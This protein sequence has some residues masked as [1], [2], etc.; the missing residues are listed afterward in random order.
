MN[1]LQ[2]FAEETLRRARLLDAAE[3]KHVHITMDTA[4]VLDHQLSAA[5]K[6]AEVVQV[7]VEAIEVSMAGSFDAELRQ[8]LMQAL[9]DAEAICEEA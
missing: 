9:K 2:T 6:L 3:K 1:K 5:R 4:P 8:E 7:L